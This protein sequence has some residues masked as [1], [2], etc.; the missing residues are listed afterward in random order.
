MNLFDMHAKYADIVD[1]NAAMSY[2]SG[3]SDSVF[4][5]PGKLTAAE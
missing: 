4:G 2:F 3:L 5:A 1:S